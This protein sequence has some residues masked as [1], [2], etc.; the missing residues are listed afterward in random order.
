[1]RNMSFAL[2]AV[3]I[4]ARQ[5]T[6]TRRLGWRFAKPGD[7]VQPVLKAQGLKKGERITTIGGPI[8]FVDVRRENLLTMIAQP[9]YG[10]SECLREG[11]MGGLMPV[12]FAAMFCEHN[13]C[14]VDTELTRIE[15]EYL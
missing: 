15:F 3:Q 13:K 7:V 14:S 4:R 8:R 11:F 12:D 9:A 6:V 10:I 2:T 5:K 1:M